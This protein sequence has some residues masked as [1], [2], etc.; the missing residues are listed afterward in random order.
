MQVARHLWIRVFAVSLCVLFCAAGWVPLRAQDA[1][2]LAGTVLDQTGKAIRGATVVVRN[3]ATG[4]S[5][6]VTTD[7]DGHFSADGLPA[8]TYTTEAVAPGFAK[9]T[10]AGIQL[11]GSEAGDVSIALGVA[12]VSQAVTVEG[13]VSLAAQLAPSK[14]PGCDFRQDGDQRTVP[15]ELHVAGFGLQRGD[16]NGAGRL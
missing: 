10:R 12:S 5:R 8:G 1:G 2:T 4:V 15:Q 16:P 6:T 14:R 11:P 3:D 9:N 13:T 7:S